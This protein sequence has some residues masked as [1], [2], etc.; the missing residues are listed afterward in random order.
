MLK[1]NEDK[2]AY[3]NFAQQNIE[4]TDAMLKIASSPLAMKIYF[5]IVK[6]MNNKNALI[7]SY[8]FFMKYF[9]AS[10]SSVCRAMRVLQE[11]NILQIK[12]KGGMSIYLLNPEIVW[13]GKGS[14]IRYCEF[15]STVVFT[16]S[17]WMKDE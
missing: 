8:E 12:R 14:Q 10:K 17:E 15:E 7:A 6:K 9:N 11:E 5:L 1:E 13:K 4:Q 3:S 16:E 2:S